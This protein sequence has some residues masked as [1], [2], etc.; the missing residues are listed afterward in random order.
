MKEELNKEQQPVKTV[1]EGMDQYLIDSKCPSCEKLI[2]SVVVGKNG[3]KCDFCRNTNILEKLSLAAKIEDGSVKWYDFVSSVSEP[4]PA[5]KDE[6]GKKLDS[7][8][9]KFHLDDEVFDGD[10]EKFLS[11]YV[12]IF[13]LCKREIAQIV[14]PEANSKVVEASIPSMPEEGSD[15]K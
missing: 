9:F 8:G 6:N 11:K 7:A 2:D 3:I 4:F 13:V 12:G 5:T 15:G 14:I 1:K 10:A